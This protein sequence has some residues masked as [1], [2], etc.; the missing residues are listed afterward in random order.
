M[1]TCKTVFEAAGG[2]DG[3]RR[4][5]Y[6]WHKRVMADDVVAHLATMPRRLGAFCVSW[7]GAVSVPPGGRWSGMRRR[8]E[9][10][11]GNAG[12]SG[13]CRTLGVCT[14][15]KIG[16]DG[17]S[18]TFACESCCMELVADSALLWVVFEFPI[19]PLNFTVLPEN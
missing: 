9:H 17:A 1:G 16:E 12:Q 4:L 10:G 2:N 15:L 11:N 13:N 6:A 5:A 3:L 18:A 7:D 19:L 14:T 8:S